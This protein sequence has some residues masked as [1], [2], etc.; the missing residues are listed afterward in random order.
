MRMLYASSCGRTL[1]CSVAVRGPFALCRLAWLRIA[2]CRAALRCPWLV[3]GIAAHCLALSHVASRR[4]C[5]ALCWLRYVAL[6]CITLLFVA[7]PCFMPCL[8]LPCLASPRL[9]MHRAV[10][11]PTTPLHHPCACTHEDTH[12]CKRGR[13]RATLSEAS[14]PKPRSP[15]PRSFG[16]S[17]LPASGSHS[18]KD[19]TGSCERA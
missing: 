15:G 17:W 18:T 12:A 9:D 1:R 14:D 16:S 11:H 3:R 8:A 7:L 13:L 6:R 2:P 4:P 5:L 10:P 19:F